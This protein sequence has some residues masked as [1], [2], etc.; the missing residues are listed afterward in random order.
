MSKKLMFKVAISALVIVVGVAAMKGKFS[1]SGSTDDRDTE[2]VFEA[3]RG[4]LVIDV[5]EGGNIHALQSLEIR[6]KVKIAAG[7]KILSIIEE[8][9]EVTEQDVKDGRVLVTLDSAPV[10]EEIVDHDVQFQETQ[11]AYAEAKQNIEVQAS[12]N[13][14]EIK[15]V[16]Q[17]ARFAL[18]D[19]EKFVGSKAAR[20]ILHSLDLPYDAETLEKFEAE[21]DQ[22]ILAAFDTE[23]LLGDV[24]E[25]EREKS[26][27]MSAA[28]APQAGDTNQKATDSTSTEKEKDAAVARAAAAAVA[29]VAEAEKRRA[30]D[31]ADGTVAD[32]LQ[33]DQNGSRAS[34]V[35]FA[36]YL[37]SERLGDGEAEQTIRRMQDEA[38]VARTE[39]AVVEEGVEGAI[40][41]HK[42]N[43]ITTT[44]LENEK[45]ALEKARLAL[46]TA[47]TE[48]DLFRDY[49]FPKEAEKM[50][51]VF[52]EALLELVREKR[53]AM[54]QA[55]Q[56]ESTFRSR[57]RRYELEL[58]KGR[59]L[60]EQIASCVIRAEKPGLVAYGGGNDNYYSS[61]YYEAIS[62]GATLKTG[63]P[64]ITIPDMSKLAV[65]VDIHESHIKKIELGQ[66]ALISVEAIADQ[67]LTGTVTKV[68]V[69]PD[70]NASRYN[71]SL[72]VYPATIEI[73]GTHDWLKPGMTAKV[74]I[75]VNELE[76][77]V[78]VPVQSIFVEDD[79]HYVFVEDGGKNTRRSVTVG[80]HNDEFI[81]ILGGIEEG[82]PVLLT[83]PV[84]FEPGEALQALEPAT[85]LS[86]TDTAEKD[87][88]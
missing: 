18:L 21:A 88:A 69:L 44:T 17:L 52:E 54:A 58:K 32:P 56:T 31:E 26:E 20:E 71:P 61:R 22:M 86:S 1:S 74:E 82:D 10:E 83:A 59:D 76:D 50:L 11:A 5:L 43:F 12:E 24:A 63:Q 39:M 49:E 73:D 87:E 14:S 46:K 2:A 77:V 75:I 53:E 25:A 68:A 8:G 30:R 41:L 6:N 64:I 55:K 66:K 13:T 16:R 42:E 35:D 28:D 79:K 23:S 29:A 27:A 70:S 9:Y 80:E 34:G 60:Q 57:K 85:Q 7:T 65:D 4:D 48:L 36:A 37:E 38:L 51:S 45:V 19:F 72:K 78:Y 81:Q 47:E 62:E 15:L 40:R 33:N 3:Q 84:E 67:S